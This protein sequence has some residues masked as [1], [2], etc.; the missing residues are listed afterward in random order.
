[1][2]L[3]LEIDLRQTKKVYGAA[4]TKL[5]MKVKKLEKTIKTN[6]ARRR[7]KIVV[8]DDE[9]DSEDSSKQGMMI[10]EIDQDAGITLVTPTKKLQV[11]ERNNYIEVD[12]EKMLV[13]LINQRKRYFAAQKAEAKRKNPM[14]QAQQRNYKVSM[15]RVLKLKVARETL[16]LH[17]ESIF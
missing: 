17:M 12:Q 11:K 6:Q 15:L 16:G 7:A 2:V 13:D 14:T 10:E 4:Y 5:I 1:M 9:E 3:A 8:F